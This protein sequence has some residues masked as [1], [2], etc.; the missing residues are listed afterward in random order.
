MRIISY[1]LLIL[2]IVTGITFA[3]LN[4]DSVQINYYIGQKTMPL[5]ILLV[6]DFVGGCVLG[7]L[8]ST[9]LL[10]KLKIKNYQLQQKIKVAEKEIDNLRAIPLQDR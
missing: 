5:S 10:L 4:P 7:L 6:I 1:I 3:L 8:V 2:V 9:G